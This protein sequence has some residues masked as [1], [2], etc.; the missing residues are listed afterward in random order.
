VTEVIVG[1]PVFTSHTC[2]G[3]KAHPAIFTDLATLGAVSFFRP[4]PFNVIVISPRCSRR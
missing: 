3:A 1:G 4:Y 2:V